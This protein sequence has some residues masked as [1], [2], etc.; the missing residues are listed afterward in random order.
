MI[1]DKG[2]VKIA[3]F[4]ISREITDTN[5]TLTS[6]PGTIGYQSPEIVSYNDYTFKTD[7]W[8]SVFWKFYEIKWT[9][10]LFQKRSCGCVLFELLFLKRF[11]EIRDIN[12]F[13]EMI[14]EKFKFL[15]LK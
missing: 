6:L 13:K 11:I 14:M 1:D 8:Y 4:G 9:I 3:D 5:G 7:I 15:L 10:V 12:D 2:H